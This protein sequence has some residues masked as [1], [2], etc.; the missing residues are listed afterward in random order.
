[1][2]NFFFKTYSVK[3]PLKIDVVETGLYV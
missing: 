2:S 3:F 1:M